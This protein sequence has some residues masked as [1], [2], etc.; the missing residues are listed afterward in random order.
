MAAWWHDL[1][2]A[3]QLARTGFHPLDGARYLHG[4]GHHTRL[5]ALVAHHSAAT[6]EAQERGLENHLAVWHRE[7]GPVADA[8]WT[9][10]MTTGP[11][12]E[13][14]EYPERLEEILGRY[15]PDSIVGRAMLRARPMIEAAVRRTEE[16][17][18][19]T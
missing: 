17:L 2:Y 5:V 1:G 14:V 3:P 4:L 6:V 13:L 15:G 7:E 19:K 8:L 10:D 18:R 12:G 16:R 11:G 9:A